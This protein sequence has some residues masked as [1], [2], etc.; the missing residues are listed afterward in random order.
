MLAGTHRF[1]TLAGFREEFKKLHEFWESDGNPNRGSCSKLFIGREDSATAGVMGGFVPPGVMIYHKTLLTAES[2][3][4]VSDG[5]CSFKVGTVSVFQSSS[6]C[7][8]CMKQ[9]GR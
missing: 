7:D 9:L 2:A 3:K 8:K 5:V 6:P 4:D 1:T